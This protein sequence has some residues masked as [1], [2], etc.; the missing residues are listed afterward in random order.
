MQLM[1]DRVCAGAARVLYAFHVLCKDIQ[2]VLEEQHMVT[3]RHLGE[4][5]SYEM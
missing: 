2:N 4:R 3:T 5:T 1:V